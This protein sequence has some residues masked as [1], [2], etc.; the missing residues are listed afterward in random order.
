MISLKSVIQSFS[1]GLSEESRNRRSPRSSSRTRQFSSRRQTS[2]LGRSE[3]AARKESG[4]W[5]EDITM[6]L[7]MRTRKCSVTTSNKQTWPRPCYNLGS[8]IR[9][10][11]LNLLIV[12]WLTWHRMQW[13][14]PQSLRA[15]S[16]PLIK[17]KRSD[18]NAR[19]KSLT[20]PSINCRS[21]QQKLKCDW[22]RVSDCR[23]AHEARCNDEILS[24]QQVCV[25]YEKS[26]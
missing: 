12:I 22:R 16:E 8:L 14:F 2:S 4:E 25:I 26:K 13:Q 18:N 9:H 24:N 6:D 15:N 21:C 5:D 23:R 19:S 3:R 1:K 17:M 20:A 10:T 7:K 11:N